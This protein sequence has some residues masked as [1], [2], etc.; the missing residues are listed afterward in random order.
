MIT[1]M[2]TFIKTY[3]RISYYIKIYLTRNHYYKFLW[4]RETFE[5]NF[6]IGFGIPN[7]SF[8]VKYPMGIGIPIEFPI[9]RRIFFLE[10]GPEIT[11]LCFN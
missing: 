1:R 7:V 4:L 9:Q 2:T 11:K 8:E 10:I 3:F 6:N 5:V